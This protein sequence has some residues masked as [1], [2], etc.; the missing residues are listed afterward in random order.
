MIRLESKEIKLQVISAVLQLDSHQLIPARELLLM[1]N[2]LL[3]QSHPPVHQGREPEPMIIDP[4]VYLSDLGNQAF[5]CGSMHMLRK[6]NKRERWPRLYPLTPFVIT[7]LACLFHKTNTGCVFLSS[8]IF[9]PRTSSPQATMRIATTPPVT[10][11][12]LVVTMALFVGH[13]DQMAVTVCPP[14]L[15]LHLITP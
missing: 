11:L 5:P 4:L 15:L 3:L 10:F 14:R 7:V 8:S 9:P 13:T 1:Q 6:G 12:N 2:S